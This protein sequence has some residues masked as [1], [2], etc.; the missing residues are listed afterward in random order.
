[1]TR[2]PAPAVRGLRPGTVVSFAGAGVGRV[3]R[4]AGGGYVLA[5][6]AAREP[7]AYAFPAHGYVGWVPYGAI[8]AVL[9][10]PGS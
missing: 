4:E 9:L 10:D 3:E 2:G 8:V 6:G 7:G 1:M 5:F